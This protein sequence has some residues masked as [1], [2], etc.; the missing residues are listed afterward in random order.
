MTTSGPGP[1][2][3][4]SRPSKE[5]V[6][7]FFFPS[8][9]FSPCHRQHLS[10]LQKDGS[11]DSC[12]S[13]ERLSGHLKG[14]EDRGIHV[15]G[16]STESELDEE[17]EDEDVIHLGDGEEEERGSYSQVGWKEE[18]ISSVT[19]DCFYIRYEEFDSG[20]TSSQ[21]VQEIFKQKC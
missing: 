19:A 14:E 5:K 7:F 16:E 21:E 17:E 1:T 6:F 10:R 3:W 8:C 20:F 12:P 13:S 4:T 2:G 15:K 18:L 9:V 11:D